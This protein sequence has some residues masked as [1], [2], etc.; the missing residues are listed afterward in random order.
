MEKIA[1]LSKS[2]PKLKSTSISEYD[3]LTIW[4]ALSYVI[5][6]ELS[7]RKGVVVPGFGT[8]TFVE[9]RLDIGTNNTQLVKMKPFFMLS[10][11]FAQTHSVDFEKEHVNLA[12]PVSRLNYVAISELT[13]RKYTRDVVEIVVNEAFTAI[14]HF[15]RS[16]GVIS[17]PFNGLGVFSVVDHSPKPKKLATFKFYE[18]ILSYLPNH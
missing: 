8:F 10:D 12:V 14:D 9:H 6:E 2:Q 17:I 16:D 15:I 13:Q 11:K 18:D 1:Q 3:V 7:K 4:D 5:R